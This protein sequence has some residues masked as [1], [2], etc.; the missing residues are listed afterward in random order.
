MLTGPRS[1][2]FTEHG[3]N[4][5]L[6]SALL[7]LAVVTIISEYIESII[8]QLQKVVEAYNRR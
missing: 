7:V 6:S 5:V 8:L 1:C 3:P 4:A 2:T